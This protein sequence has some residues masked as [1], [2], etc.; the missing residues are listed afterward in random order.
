MPKKVDLNL[1]AGDTVLYYG[2][3]PVTAFVITGADNTLGQWD[4]QVR[5][6]GGDLMGELTLT[7]DES[8]AERIEVAIE[9]GLSQRLGAYKTA[10][11]DMQ[12][13]FDDSTVITHIYGTMKVTPDVTQVDL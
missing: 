2:N 3:E 11:W 1:Y 4:A 6:E 13:T 9:A 12:Q 5:I 10:K 8:N 7:P